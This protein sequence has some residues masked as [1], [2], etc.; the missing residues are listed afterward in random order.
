[1]LPQLRLPARVTGALGSSDMSQVAPTQY[2]ADTVVV[3]TDEHTRKP[4]MA[5]VIEPQGRDR[6]TK[7]VS[8]PNNDYPRSS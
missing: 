8:R 2:V 6:K 1:M 4:V 3:L 7:K 5:V